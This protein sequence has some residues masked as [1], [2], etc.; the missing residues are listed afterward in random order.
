MSTTQ[1]Q[2]KQQVP[3]WWLQ[4]DEW[5]RIYKKKAKPKEVKK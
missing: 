4:K 5:E 1:D 2:S 3:E